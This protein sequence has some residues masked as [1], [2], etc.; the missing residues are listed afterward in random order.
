MVVEPFATL[1]ASGQLQ[2]LF[3]PYPLDLLVIDQKALDLQKLMDLAISISAI[4][5]GQPDHGQALI[6]IALL[7]ALIAQGA[8][9]NPKNLACPP[10]GCA[11][12]LAC[13]NDRTLQVFSTQIL[14]FKKSRLS[15]RIS[16]SS[17]RSA[18]IFLSRWFSFSRAFNSVS[19]GFAI[20][21]NFLRQI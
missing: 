13:L 11:E 17:S 8:A 16:L 18:T 19:C 6:I 7:G 3:P 20:P 5:L 15:F 9:G 10:L 1:M 4:L 21:P 14:G 12:L 2:T